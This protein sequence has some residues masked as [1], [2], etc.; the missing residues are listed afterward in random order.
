MNKPKPGGR[1]STP[2][3]SLVVDAFWSATTRRRCAAANWAWKLPSRE[4]ICHQTSTQL[5]DRME[6]RLLSRA[7]SNAGCGVE[8]SARSGENAGRL[9]DLDQVAV[10]VSDI[11]ADLA[12]MVL[13][14][15][16]ERCALRRPFLVGLGNVGDANVE[17]RACA[18][19]VGWRNESDGG[20]VVSR[21]A[22][23]IQDQPRVRNLHDDRVA[24]DE[25]LTVEQRS[26]ELTGP[27]LVGNH[28]KV[29]NY[30]T[31]ARRGK[32]LWVHITT[33]TFSFVSWRSD[34]VHLARDIGCC[35]KR[36]SPHSNIACDAMR[37]SSA[38]RCRSVNKPNRRT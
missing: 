2:P 23:D 15:S 20:L 31:V 27:V 17:E 10:G 6:F 19:G 26:I 3:Q 36:L 11:R 21:T 13:R 5:V 14:L 1:S 8:C 9:A 30:E 4:A 33:S 32:V 7:R 18:V 29:R 35:A 34:Y 28:Q 24:L 16:E 25:N 38:A 22:P 12:S 37:D